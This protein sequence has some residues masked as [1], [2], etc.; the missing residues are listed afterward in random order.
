[1]TGHQP[2]N[3]A[4]HIWGVCCSKTLGYRQ[5]NIAIAIRVRI[6]FSLK[7]FFFMNF[8]CYYSDYIIVMSLWYVCVYICKMIPL[9]TSL[10]TTSGSTTCGHPGTPPH[11]TTSQ[12]GRREFLQGET[13]TYSCSA[14]Y[15]LAGSSSTTCLAQ[16]W[17]RARPVCSKYLY[18]V[19]IIQ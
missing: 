5:A 6:L 9:V 10:A 17:S 13:V 2:L 7:R 11:S 14:G 12:G 3:L 16:G 4:I 1:M 19:Q 15:V 8:R 18:H